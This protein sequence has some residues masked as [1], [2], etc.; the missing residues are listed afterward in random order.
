MLVFCWPLPLLVKIDGTTLEGNIP[1]HSQD[2][3]KSSGRVQEVPHPYPN[4]TAPLTLI[5]VGG[6]NF[7]HPL[8]VFLYSLNNSETVKSV[9]LAF[10]SNQQHFIRDIRAKFG[11]PYSP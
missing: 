8:L 3:T 2:I 6:D 4:T 1:N 9:T 5:W 11:I 7:T 10:C